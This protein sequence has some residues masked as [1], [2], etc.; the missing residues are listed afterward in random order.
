MMVVFTD[1]LICAMRSR[2]GLAAGA[3]PHGRLAELLG[4]RQQL[5][6]RAVLLLLVLDV[7]VDEVGLQDRVVG[8]EADVGLGAAVELGD[9][10]QALARLGPVVVAQR[11]DRRRVLEVGRRGRS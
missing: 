10:A 7:V 9:L 11:D 8:L 4:D 5:A 1:D 6:E 2:Y 3:L